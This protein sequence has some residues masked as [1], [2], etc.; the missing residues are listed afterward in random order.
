MLYSIS[1]RSHGCSSRTQAILFTLS[2]LYHAKSSGPN[3]R[4]NT[5]YPN[6][7]SSSKFATTLNPK[8]PPTAGAFGNDTVTKALSTYANDWNR[9]FEFFNWVEAQHRFR[10][11][12]DTYNVMI[13]ILGKF[14]EFPTCWDLIRTMSSRRC[15]P[16]HVTFRIMFKRYLS[17]HLVREA[18]DTYDG[19]GEFNLKDKTSFCN[20]IDALCEYKHVV[21]AVEL[22][23][24]PNRRPEFDA[25]TKLYNMIL[26]GWFKLGWWSKCREFWEDMD[27]KGVKKDLH[28]YSI[29]MDI[30]YKSGKPWKTIKL[31]KEMKQK[32]IALD[33]VAYNIVIRAVGLSEGVDSSI[34]L[35]REMIDL[36]CQPNTVTLN[37]IIKLLC[38]NS[39]V[40]DACGMLEQMSR[41]G[42]DPNAITY[43]CLFGY[44]EKP[45]EI[46]KLFDKMTEDG[47]HPTMDT[48][49]M[50]IRK[51]GRWGFLRPV[52]IIWNKM[53]ERGSS[54]SEFAYN[55]L[56]DVLLQ[57]GMIDMARKYDEEML[58]KGLSS[59]LR[60]EIGTK[61]A[62]AEYVNGL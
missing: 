1:G 27:K 39:R 33:V 47:V 9:A 4:S 2:Q 22:C 13:D 31:F 17:A 10:H 26:R 28:S 48:F 5:R 3:S 45:N 30:T 21:E 34:A 14:L 6:P 32:K 20:L 38:E 35:Y 61:L 53:E 58:K 16:N 41:K 7:Q 55:A 50:L 57:K 56:I 19:L 8:P 60:P 42:C 36:G 49:V 18:I 40:K 52:F 23:M 12:A 24:G 54:P 15:L 51:F 59:K 29:Y 43:H 62:D 37:T 44:L 46:L 11:T 25:S